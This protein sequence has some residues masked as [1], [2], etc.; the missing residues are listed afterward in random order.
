MRRPVRHP[1][2]IVSALLLLA[3]SVAD[4]EGQEPR[5]STGGTCDFSNIPGVVWFGT[6]RQM[7]IQRLASYLAPVYWFSPDEP[8]LNQL[9]GD[10]IRLPEA[11]PFE[12][13]PDRPVVYYQFDHILVNEDLQE[14]A[15]VRDEAGLGDAM[16]DLEALGAFKL[17]FFAYF[18]SEV[19]LGAHQHD[20]EAAEFKV[21]VLRSG[22]EFV[23]ENT[24]ARCDEQT[25]VVL[26]TRVSAKAHGIIWFWNV[27]DTDE[28]TRFPMHLLVEEGKHGLATDKNGDGY[29]TPGYDVSRH[30]N[31][32]WGIRDNIR[33]GQLVTGGYQSWMTKVRQPEHRVYPPLPEDSPG[34]ARLARRGY[35]DP[36]VS[37]V[38]YELR[39]F[40]SS[41][42]AAD[43]PGLYHFM[44]PKDVPNWPEVRTGRSAEDVLDWVDEGSVV[45]SLAISLMTDGD[46]GFSFVFPFFIVKNLETDISGGFLVWRLYLKDVKLRD[47]GAMLM[48]AP[49]ASR[50]FDTY[51][52]FGYEWYE[53]G[54]KDAP[55]KFDD[56][57]LET[58]FK[59]R[60][61]LG[62][63][64]LKFLTFF[65]DFWGFRA[66]IKNYGFTDIDRLTYVLEFGAGAW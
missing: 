30:I 40:P 25:Y 39:P 49:S 8:L 24:D 66:G 21:V 48:Y 51:F 64:P 61:Q 3:F 43:D 63:S 16:V 13:A 22:G 15:Y 31:D 6:D 23:R 34:R 60:V 1:Q 14:T 26:V 44:E 42:L 57:V 35:Y 4:A 29:F 47:F 18:S 10:S 53:E 65:T 58:G 56:F 59:F 41:E 62:T 5:Y 36:D 12:T 46:L 27:I 33:S 17:H 19:G 28:E 32:A 11:L 37:Y 20:L 7:P 50:W 54:P 9:E 52:A 45:K 2:L 55:E 38:E